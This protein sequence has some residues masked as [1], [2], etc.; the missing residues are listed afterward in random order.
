MSLE[1]TRK[2]IVVNAFIGVL[3]WGGFL[4]P[5]MYI[6]LKKSKAFKEQAPLFYA[7]AGAM[8]IAIL[9]YL[10]LMLGAICR[11]PTLILVYLVVFPLIQLIVVVQA[12][13]L[14]M[15][16]FEAYSGRPGRC[17]ELVASDFGETCEDLH[18]YSV[19]MI[20]LAAMYTFATLMVVCFWNN[21]RVFWSELRHRLERKS[22]RAV[23]DSE[24]SKRSK[25]KK[26]HKKTLG[27]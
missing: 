3:C 16:V 26:R 12:S 2:G 18:K 24:R 19:L 4:V 15:A 21:V 1:D 23:E 25:K 27:R 17:R 22:A 14:A 8:A 20:I 10:S 9:A 5:Y 7:T 6:P 13:A 11:D